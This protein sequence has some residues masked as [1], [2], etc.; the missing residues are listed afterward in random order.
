FLAGDAP[1]IRRAVGQA[2]RR[3]GRPRSTARVDH[4]AANLTGDHF[5]ASLAGGNRPPLQARSPDRRREQRDHRAAEQ[6]SLIVPHDVSLFSRSLR[7]SRTATVPPE[8]DATLSLRRI[9]LARRGEQA[10][11]GGDKGHDPGVAN[12]RLLLRPRAFDR[13]DIADLQ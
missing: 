1:E 2:R 5:T 8:A 7:L 9:A 4:A 12:M 6:A 11:A 10:L 13:H 3:F